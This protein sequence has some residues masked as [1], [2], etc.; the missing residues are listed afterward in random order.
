[1][2]L[3]STLGNL[4]KIGALTPHTA[5]VVGHKVRY[6]VAQ[7]S[8]ATVLLRVQAFIKFHIESRCTPIR[9]SS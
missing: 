9:A 2:S 7:A 1:M 5:P 3:E 4:K 8:M 6:F